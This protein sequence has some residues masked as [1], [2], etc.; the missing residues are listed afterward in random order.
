M[1]TF[2]NR[3]RYARELRC[4]TQAELA[5][6]AKVSQSAIANYENG[7]RKSAK[8]IFKLAGALQ[9]SPRWLAEGVPPME[10]S[11]SEPGSEYF[12]E[13]SAQSLWPFQLISPLQWDALS[14][15]DKQVVEHTITALLHTKKS[16]CN[17][18]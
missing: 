18:S 16:Q 1:D 15:R 12:A 17:A 5:R 2:A 10:P 4:L 7:T 13:N 11:L 14:E 8:N 6:A 9:L 3:L